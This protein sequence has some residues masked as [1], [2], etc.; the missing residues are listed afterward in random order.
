MEDNDI[1][2]NTKQKDEWWS[3][4]FHFVLIIAY[5]VFEFGYFLVTFIMFIIIS[6]E[7]VILFIFGSP[8]VIIIINVSTR[9]AIAFGSLHIFLL[10]L[11]DISI[12]FITFC[13]YFHNIHDRHNIK[14]ISIEPSGDGNESFEILIGI[15]E[16][17]RESDEEKEDKDKNFLDQLK[18]HRKEFHKYILTTNKADK[19]LTLAYNY[20][21]W[22]MFCAHLNL[23]ICSLLI[24]EWCLWW[25]FD[26]YH[27]DQWLLLYSI[28]WST[29]LP[30]V[31]IFAMIKESRT[32]SR[33]YLI[34]HYSFSI[35]QI[36]Y[37]I[38]EISRHVNFIQIKLD[39]SSRIIITSLLGMI[40]ILAVL[41]LIIPCIV[42][43]SLY[44]V[45]FFEGLKE[46]KKH[47]L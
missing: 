19:K 17:K 1:V 38:F 46:L 20:Y 33:T 41:T 12:T 37:C 11:V 25:I 28:P 30:S 22:I 4:N 18:I 21:I 36:L 16:K 27:E 24:V 40:F 43:L 2:N 5:Y 8:L 3:S 10:F 42:G 29:L 15:R 14:K 6:H 7:G 45:G 47:R 32:A 44:N 13:L 34:I 35:L 31:N 9:M 39:S 23:W 26:I